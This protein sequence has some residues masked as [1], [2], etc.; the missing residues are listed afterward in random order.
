M[1]ILALWSGKELHAQ[2]AVVV[3]IALI[4]LL[5]PVGH[6]G[7]P[8]LH[9]ELAL[10]ASGHHDAGRVRCRGREREDG[11]RRMSVLGGKGSRISGTL[12]E[13]NNE[14]YSLKGTGVFEVV[15]SRPE[16]LTT[17]RFLRNQTVEEGTMRCCG[18]GL[19]LRSRSRPVLCSAYTLSAGLLLDARGNR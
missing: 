16:P 8:A 12:E 19:C 14:Q 18:S 3:A 2:R 5:A 10:P 7:S 17:Q 4:P 6:E 11:R 1:A 13:E 9:L 15:G